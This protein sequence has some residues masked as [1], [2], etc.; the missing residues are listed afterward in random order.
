MG[1]ESSQAGILVG[2]AYLPSIAKN[3][4]A[5][6]KTL[7]LVQTQVRLEGTFWTNV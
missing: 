2:G 4:T 1:E 6:L 3:G 7:A 5:Q